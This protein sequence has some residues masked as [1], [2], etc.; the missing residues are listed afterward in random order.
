[1]SKYKV[2]SYLFIL[3]GLLVVAGSAYVIVS[4]ASNLLNAI[5]EFVTTNDYTKLRECGVTPPAQFD[6][7]KNDLTS[8]ILPFLYAGFPLLLIL[9]SFLM[10]LA[11]FYYHRG[12]LEDEARKKEELEREMVHKIVKKMETEKVPSQPTKRVVE[13]QIKETEKEVPAEME[14]PS[15]TEEEPS[16]E[17]P[18]EEEPEEKAAEEE[19]KPA[20]KTVKKKK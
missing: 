1:M 16:S 19:E 17:E 14:E 4:Y 20:P 3:L 18:L 9:I 8:V 15:E 12:K 11:G 7:V 10:F 5:V 2:V 13:Q 6:R